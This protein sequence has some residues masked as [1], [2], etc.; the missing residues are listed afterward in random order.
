M[1]DVDKAIKGA[2]KALE[3]IFK[4]LKSEFDNGNIDVNSLYKIV[5]QL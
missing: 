5:K 4:I 1:K 3:D 2:N